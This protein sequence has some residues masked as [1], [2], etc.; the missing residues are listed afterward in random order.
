METPAKIF[1]TQPRRF[2]SELDKASGKN[3]PRPGGTEQNLSVKANMK[4]LRLPCADYAPTGGQ[5]VQTP[6]RDL[7]PGPQVEMR[8]AEDHQ[9]DNGQKPLK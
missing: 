8:G 6:P 3:L 7:L 9:W 1:T 4:Q 5:E 2:Q